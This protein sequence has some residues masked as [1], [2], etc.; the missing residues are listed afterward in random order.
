[1]AVSGGRDSMTLQS[2]RQKRLMVI[3]GGQFQVP[4]IR[5]A[6]DM[7]LFVINSNLYPDS[8]GF[9]CSDVGLVADVRDRKK[10]LEFARQYQPDG[11][12]TDQTDLSVPTVAYLCEELGLPGIGLATAEL[13]TNKYQMRQFLR[14]R[15]YPT[16]EYRL[17]QSPEDAV[18]FVAK[19]GYPIVLKPP[20]N[21]GSRG[22]FVVETDAELP[23]RYAGASRFSHDRNVLAEQFLPGTELSVE[24][25]KSR[26]RHYSLAVARK[27][28]FAHN[29]MVAAELTYAPSAED[30]DFELLKHE[31]NAMVEEMGLRFGITHA[32]YVFSQGRF[33]L[34]EVAA[35]GGGNNVSS[36]IVPAISGVNVNELLIRM[37]LGEEIDSLAPCPD[38]RPFVVL[39]FFNFEPGIV[40]AVCGV[41]TVRALP[42]LM[43][44][45]IAVRPGQL[46]E[47]PSDGTSRHGYFMAAAG[48]AGELESLRRRIFEEV[49]VAYE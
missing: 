3:A 45:F 13:F 8:P 9:R 30:M 41:E 35:R 16:P 19:V 47:P 18:D 26:K 29:P 37:S 20:A 5:T 12:V 31:H 15:G 24:G 25:F 48:S 39:S 34:I 17:C 40:R 27:K 38:G 14:Q 44:I 49:R 22:V 32:E 7:D 46:L 36:H 2:M 21:Q 4:L 33:V 43:D 23:D 11:I 28:G 6:K 1:M 10:N 42:G